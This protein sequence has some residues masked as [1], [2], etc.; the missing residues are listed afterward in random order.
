MYDWSS[1]YSLRRV[2]FIPCIAGKENLV[3]LKILGICS[4]VQ[5]NM[6]KKRWI[7]YLFHAMTVR[8]AS[9]SSGHGNWQRGVERQEEAEASLMGVRNAADPKK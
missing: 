3:V 8:N 1:I 9:G 7:W 4:E 5:T 2:M 6:M